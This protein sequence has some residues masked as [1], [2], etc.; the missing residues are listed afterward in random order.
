MEQE[1]AL[2]AWVT[3]SLPRNTRQVGAF[4]VKKFGIVY[5]SR[6]GLIAL[7]PSFGVGVPEV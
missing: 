5:E 4:I 7:L 3:A 2:K 6:S 1:T